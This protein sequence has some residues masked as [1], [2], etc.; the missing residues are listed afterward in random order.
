VDAG[1]VDLARA[2]HGRGLGVED[3]HAHVGARE[4]VRTVEPEEARADHE[5]VVGLHVGHAVAR[6]SPAGTP[7][8][9][10]R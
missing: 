5:P 8:S 9:A 1:L 7:A 6:V 3:G 2:Q 4:Q 10:P